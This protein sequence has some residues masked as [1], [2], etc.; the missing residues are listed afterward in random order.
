[1][2]CKY[3]ENCEYVLR[4]KDYTCNSPDLVMQETCPLYQ[5][6]ED[7]LGIK[8]LKEEKIPRFIDGVF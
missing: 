7:K 2:V 4:F 1:M 8:K 3:I 5:T 6:I